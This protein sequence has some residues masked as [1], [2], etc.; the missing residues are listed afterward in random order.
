MQF[1]HLFSATIILYNALIK[2]AVFH[3]ADAGLHPEWFFFLCSFA[4]LLKGLRLFD[5]P[6]K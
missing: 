3:F 5:W 4:K 6:G 1:I 2:V